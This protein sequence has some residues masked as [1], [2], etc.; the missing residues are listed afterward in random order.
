[1]RVNLVLAAAI[2]FGLRV[3]VTVKRQYYLLSLRYGKI[4]NRE[5]N[6]KTVERANTARR[7]S[8]V[9]SIMKWAF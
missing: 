8:K 5:G 2:T 4:F 6:F 3:L 9:K 1:M 7:K